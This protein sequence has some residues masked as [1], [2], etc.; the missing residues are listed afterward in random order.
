VLAGL[1]VC[2]LSGQET[3]TEAVA[4]T[5]TLSGTL[6]LEPGG[7]NTSAAAPEG[8][9]TVEVL[10]HSS[11]HE[12][13]DKTNTHRRNARERGFGGAGGPLP[14]LYY[15]DMEPVHAVV[16]RYEDLRRI[17]FKIDEG[18]APFSFMGGLGYGGVGHGVRIGGGGL[19]G[20]RSFA[21]EKDTLVL[22]NGDVLI[23]KMY[24]I[25]V[26]VGYGGF[27][28]EKAV[29]AGNM[30]FFVGGFIGGGGFE[31]KVSYGDAGDLLT[32]T[33]TVAEG[34]LGQFEAAFFALDLHGG[35]TYTM[36]PWFHLGF[37][38]SAPLFL[39][40]EGFVRDFGGIPVTDGFTTFNGGG[41][42]R[43]IF[44]NLG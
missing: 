41:G 40:T 25:E 44:G 19:G 6:E 37:E 28:L 9:D 36:L 4:E 42:L 43:F 8:K 32:V 3:A 5:D 12:F 14:S 23:D 39:S 30:N 24:E 10:T 18:H 22:G 16:N 13:L 33:E 17:G 34:T 29:V 2:P 11:L 1:L 31:V 21:A 7:E 27:L 26:N 38:L 15:I 35:M 20:T